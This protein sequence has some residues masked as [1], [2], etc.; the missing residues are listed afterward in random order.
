VFYIVE[1]D[2]KRQPLMFVQVAKGCLPCHVE[3][4]PESMD[5]R[6]EEWYLVLAH[7]NVF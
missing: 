7:I 4:P 6:R 5:A 3:A 2:E 1:L